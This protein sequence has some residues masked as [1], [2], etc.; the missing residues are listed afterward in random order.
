MVHSHLHRGLHGV[1]PRKL[2][3]FTHTAVSLIVFSGTL[4]ALKP[5]MS[6]VDEAAERLSRIERLLH[7]LRA[8][9]DAVHEEAKIASESMAERSEQARRSGVAA[10]IRADER[11][12]ETRRRTRRTP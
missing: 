9:T 11:R 5:F 10:R 3:V 4:G 12:C 8:E 6:H 7:E 2:S 1:C